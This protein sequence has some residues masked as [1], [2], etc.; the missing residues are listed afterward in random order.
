MFYGLCFFYGFRIVQ[1]KY[2]IKRC[3]DREEATDVCKARVGSKV[4]DKI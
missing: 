1:I 4:N 2:R 3:R